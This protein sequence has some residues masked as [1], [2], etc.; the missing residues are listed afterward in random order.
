MKA[1]KGYNKD[2]TGMRYTYGV[3][4][5]DLTGQSL[6]NKYSIDE[7]KKWCYHDYVICSEK[8]RV[9]GVS[10]AVVWHKYWEFRPR[11]HWGE[12]GL[13]FITFRWHVNKYRWADKIVWRP[14]SEVSE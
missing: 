6:S 2:M 12:L 4:T 7:C 9:C 13:G 14:E 1:Y 5:S 10:L 3:Y 8:D 11:W